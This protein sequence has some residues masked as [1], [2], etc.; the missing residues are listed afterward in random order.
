MKICF[1]TK[2]EKLYVDHVA[3]GPP[4][5]VLDSVLNLVDKKY[6]EDV[7]DYFTAKKLFHIEKS[8]DENPKDAFKKF[9]L[10]M[11]AMFEAYD[12]GQQVTGKK[13]SKCRGF[14]TY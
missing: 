10:G 7:I 2:R 14:E 1:L 5:L 8:M 3:Y 6:Q 12:K 13:Y 9:Q 11:K 4:Q